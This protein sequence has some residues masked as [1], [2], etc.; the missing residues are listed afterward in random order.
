MSLFAL[1]S[2]VLQM[3]KNIYLPPQFQLIYLLKYNML[4]Y[5]IS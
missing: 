4:K 2:L 1:Y 3:L 5:T